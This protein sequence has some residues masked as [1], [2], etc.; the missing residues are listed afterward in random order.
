MC[1]IFFFPHQLV[2]DGILAWGGSSAR[3]ILSY[4]YGHRTRMDCIYEFSVHM[5]TKTWMPPNQML[6]AG[7]LLLNFS[8][9][10]AV[11]NDHFI[12]FM[13]TNYLSMVS[14]DELWII[15]NATP[16]ECGKI[17]RLLLI[18]KHHHCSL[19]LHYSLKYVNILPATKCSF[20]S[21]KSHISV[22]NDGHRATKIHNIILL[23]F[24][25]WA[26]PHK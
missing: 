25:V 16:F 20:T 26:Y 17:E 13:N 8:L 3:K 2:N 1:I 15:Y 18:I 23:Y 4:P 5:F 19:T 6:P 12:W 14:T 24:T 10:L 7:F 11:R 9:A 22:Q 21:I